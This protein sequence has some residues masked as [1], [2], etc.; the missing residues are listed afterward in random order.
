[1]IPV[2]APRLDIEECRTE[3]EAEF[4]NE[5]HGQAAHH[6]WFGMGWNL[7]DRVVVTIDVADPVHNVVLRVLRADYWDQYL[8]LGEDETKQLATNLDPSQPGVIEHRGDAVELANIA[9]AWFLQEMA[10]PIERL[11]WNRIS[12]QRNVWRLADSGRDLVYQDS[13]NDWSTDL[14]QPDRIVPVLT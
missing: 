8:M 14:G 12:R 4:I 10:R 6:G 3:D 11:A 5:L 13:L 2:N 7:H 9:A 1:M